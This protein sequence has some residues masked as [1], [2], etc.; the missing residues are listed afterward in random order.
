MAIIITILYPFQGMQGHGAKFPCAWC[1]GTAPFKDKAKKRTLGD[2]KKLVNQFNEEAGGD[3]KYAMDYYNCILPSLLDGDDD[4]LILDLCP[5]DELH[6]LLG[7]FKHA[8]TLQF[9]F[10]IK[11]RIIITRNQLGEVFAI[12]TLPLVEV[13][14]CEGL[15]YKKEN[16][17][18]TFNIFFQASQIIFMTTLT[19]WLGMIP[20]TIGVIHT[21]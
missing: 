8:F 12:L 16:E 17:Y 15:L 6:V 7:K 11:L 20:C 9:Y 3:K 2:L 18:L 14:Y 21:P 19:L 10:F 13:T 4:T 1:F 5:I